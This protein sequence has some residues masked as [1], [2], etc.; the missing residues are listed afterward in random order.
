VRAA[1][2]VNAKSEAVSRCH[3]DILLDSEL[4][5]DDRIIVHTRYPGHAR[6]L[7]QQLSLDRFDTIIACGGDGTVNEI[8]NGMDL[9][10]CSLAI[11]PMGT[12]NDLAHHY[13]IPDDLERA[14]SVVSSGHVHKQDLLSANGWKYATVGGIGLGSQV[15]QVINRLRC[16]T[17]ADKALGRALGWRLY[18]LGL[19]LAFLGNGRKP[20]R[21]GLKWGEMRMEGSYSSIIVGNQSSLGN[22]FTVLPEAVNDDGH[23]EAFGIKAEIG[24]IDLLS[25]ISKIL[26]GQTP[27]PGLITQLRSS[28]LI[29]KINKPSR[30]FADGEIGDPTGELVIEIIPKALSV[31]V[32]DNWRDSRR[33]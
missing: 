21:A 27:N 4:R 20:F 14:L 18:I 13:G 32:P 24:P 2:I 3:L 6:E 11:I 15:L 1:A 30:F 25:I 23:F 7:A 31:I 16:H 9:T 17:W 10:S 26:R 8:I 28:K 29:I 19:F 22:R 5:S 12:A 33:G